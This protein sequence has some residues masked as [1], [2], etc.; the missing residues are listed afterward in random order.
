MKIRPTCSY[1][2][3]YF[4]PPEWT[5]EHQESMEK[6]Q[7]E[8]GIFSNYTVIRVHENEYPTP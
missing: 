7:K 2:F 6:L 4:E 1:D 5:G 8:T 3:C